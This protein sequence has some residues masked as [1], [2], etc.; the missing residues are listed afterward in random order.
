M[1][2]FNK[3]L[4]ALLLA[5]LFLLILAQPACARA[6]LGI[7]LAQ[8]NR[9]QSANQLYLDK[10]IDRA[11]GDTVVVH[12]YTD[13][14]TLLGMLLKFNKLDAALLSQ[15]TYNKQVPGSL[16]SLAN[17]QISDETNQTNLI[18]VARADLAESQKVLLIEGY[19][20]L[21]LST[22]GLNL[23]EQYATSITATKISG[24]T[25]ANG[26]EDSVFNGTLTATDGDGLTDGTIFSVTGAA[27][28]GRAV[29]NESSG[30]WNYTPNADYNGR[31]SFTVTVTDDAG[32][33]TT[34]EVSLTINKVSDIVEDSDTTNEDAVVVTNVLANDTFEATPTVTAVSQGTNGTVAIVDG[35]KGTV[36]YNPDANFK[37]KDTY[38]YSVSRGGI[39]ETAKVTITVAPVNVPTTIGGTTSAS[40]DEDSVINGT[41]TATDGNGLTDGTIFSVTG[42]ATNG[43]A[44]INEASGVWNY[45]PNADYNGRDSFIVT[46]T[47]DAGNTTTQEVSLTINKV[48]DIVEDNDTT[49]EDALVV[50]TVLARETLEAT[51]TVTARPTP[52][53]EDQVSKG[54][55]LTALKETASETIPD[56]PSRSKTSKSQEWAAH[57]ELKGRLGNDSIIGEA[58]LFF[59]ITQNANSM[60]FGDLR[61]QLDDN[62]AKE[63]NFGLGYRKI[64]NNSW[65]LGGYGFY[66]LRKSENHNDF[67]QFTLGAEAMTEKYSARVNWYLA[68]EEEY[69]IKSQ[70][71][72]NQVIYSG[73]TLIHQ[74]GG[75]AFKTMEKSMSGFDAEIGWVLPWFRSQEVHGY[76]GGFSFSAAG[77]DDISG[78]KAR[79]E[80]RFQD[81]FSWQGSFFEIGG[82]VRHDDV[83]DTDYFVSARARIPFGVFSK[84]FPEPLLGLRKR[85]TERIQRDP[86]IIVAE[87]HE[88]SSTPVHNEIL[89]DNNNQIS[90]AHVDSQAGVGDGTVE[91]PFNTLTAANSTDSEI[92]LLYSDSFFDGEGF[93]LTANQ[94]LLGE[95]SE[96]KVNTDQL[97]RINL[98]T[99][100]GG[101]AVPV[102][103]NAG[104]AVTLADGSEVSRINITNS[105]TAIYGNGVG[106][107]NVNHIGI[108]GVNYGI[109]LDELVPHVNESFITDNSINTVGYDGIHIKN[110]NN[111]GEVFVN[112][113]NNDLQNIGTISSD[114]SG[115]VLENE[116]LG[117]GVDLS[118]NKISNVSNTGIILDNKGLN[119][120]ASVF[121]NEI[122]R[123]FGNGIFVSNQSPGKTLSINLQKN[124]IEAVKFEG[125]A[126]D[127]TG[128]TANLYLYGNHVDGNSL[129]G[130]PE[131]YLIFNR[132]GSSVK[133]GATTGNSS[134]GNTYT[135]TDNG[136][137]TDEGNTR[138][139][140]ATLPNVIIFG[141]LEVVDKAKIPGN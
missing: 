80:V 123:T 60:L 75:Q 36:S 138:A 74:T 128:E 103:R 59:P 70:E 58:D 112:I 106:G 72:L 47:D 76:L 32:N 18:L 37:G 55:S 111:A 95:S 124:Q 29:I 81:A 78:P 109:S 57:V 114:G 119:L 31:D 40:G 79:L 12:N 85:M 102:I 89:T 120:W 98:P 24:A 135:N 116:G 34:Q 64:I 3:A 130:D 136:V 110:I 9:Q 77:M 46:V 125:I 96:H 127:N 66:D 88:D 82:E 67:D 73:T 51:P 83:R 132:A 7:S 19:Q 87:R 131:D 84:D 25:S 26:D 30:V 62:D 15:S 140:G 129:A 139:D 86:D 93:T 68:D 91:A 23:L 105:T 28:N 113:S 8:E 35:N 2:R 53:K 100:S 4:P 14:A 38:T 121:D 141:E 43:R 22:E 65:V 137:L 11:F 54:A 108:T 6:L 33:T 44:F 94:R 107:V 99:I 133:L 92:V 115:I 126:I 56:A 69:L 122:S 104:T 20:E 5:C 48:S 118:G 134:I 97:G 42:T 52:A 13:Q 1:K 27:T 17:L 21:L 45:T 16:S 39:T 117:L 41:L 71:S 10:Q 61:F 50:T 63:G 101:T 49:N 90:I